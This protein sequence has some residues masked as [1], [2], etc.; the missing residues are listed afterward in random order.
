MKA[1]IRKE[2]EWAQE[3]KRADMFVLLLT[4]YNQQAD[5][6][7]RIKAVKKMSQSEHLTL[8]NNLLDKMSTNELIL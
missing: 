3:L 2:E 8:L 4:Y 1:D 7:D 5:M 6:M